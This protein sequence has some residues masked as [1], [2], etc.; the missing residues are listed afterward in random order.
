MTRRSPTLQKAQDTLRF[1]RAHFNLFTSSIADHALVVLDTDGRVLRWHSGAERVLGWSADEIIG[2][3]CAVFFTAEDVAKNVPFLELEAAAQRGYIAADRWHVRRDGKRFWGSG[4]LSAVRIETGELIGFTKI[5]RDMTKQ[6]ETERLLQDSQDRLRLFIEHVTDYALLQV[7]QEARICSWNSGAERTFGYREDEIVGAPVERL[8]GPEDVAKGDIAKDLDSARDHGRFE[9]AR[10][11]VRKDGSRLFARWVTTPMRDEAGRLRGYAKVLRDETHRRS[12]EEQTNASLT[13]KEALLQ[14]IHHRVKNNLQVIASLL[15]IQAS[16]ISNREVCAVL[17]DT[18]HRVRAIA[19]LHETLY[20]S[21][22]LANIEFGSYLQQLVG[23]LLRFYRVDKRVLRVNID[24]ADM[25][26]ELR[27]ALPLGLILNELVTNALKHAFPEG[28]SGNL[29]VQLK[30]LRNAGDACK[31]RTL[32]EGFAQLTVRDDG[33]GLPLN[34]NLDEIPS[35][36]LHLVR[37]LTDQLRG[38]LRLLPLK[39]PQSA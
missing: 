25:V 8:Y 15:S 31:E 28:R 39:A 2:Q 33:V 21:E 16:R 19:A 22:D 35:M 10:W 38:E 27:Q 17:A 18:E 7:D 3:S 23:D 34:L 14:E 37:L 11:M 9:D 1:E 29:E 32:D 36:G 6:R 12:V 5:V 24:A 4:S 20:S 30:Y 13:E 26:I